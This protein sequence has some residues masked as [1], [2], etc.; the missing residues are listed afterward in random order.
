MKDVLFGFVEIEG[1]EYPFCFRNDDFVLQV[2]PPDYNTCKKDTI[3]S[4]EM[5]GQSGNSE[6]IDHNRFYGITS[7][8]RRVC[9]DVIAISRLHNGF[10]DYIVEWYTIYNIE[11]ELNVID[12]LILYGGDLN[13]YY[14]AERILTTDISVNDNGSLDWMSIMAR[15][16][17]PLDC[18]KYR[19]TRNVD[20]EI[21][22]NSYATMRS[23]NFDNP[24]SATSN[25]TICFSKSLTIDSALLAI[26]HI[27]LFLKYAC[28]RRNI[29]FS[30]IKMFM[31]D[32]EG[33]KDPFG[34]IYFRHRFEED[35]HPRIRQRIIPYSFWRDRMGKMLTQIKNGK[36]E[37]SH[38][39]NSIE[40]QK[41]YPISRIIL[42]FTAFEREYRNIYGSNC[43]RS[44]EYL[45]AKK[46]VVNH[47]VSFSSQYSG[48]KKKY[49]RN[50]AKGIE[51]SD[52]SYSDRVRFALN[53]C[54][55]IMEP[56]ILRKY[57]QYSEETLHDISVRTGNMRNSLAHSKLDLQLE[58][59]SLKDVRIIE[60]LTYA[61]RLK[62][63]EKD[64]SV[65][66]KAIARLFGEIVV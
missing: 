66:R 52:D 26:R 47:L 2:I 42:V 57:G 4:F 38:L 28:Y 7:E 24:F 33:K 15:P 22:V 34:F 62:L 6:W 43:L 5:F 10:R 29:S 49:I 35:K 20:A 61:I 59:I 58:Q 25:M 32:S 8:N 63:I 23:A 55:E 46:D 3:A 44:E 11:N 64:S 21:K 41:H 19:I 36:L 27:E 1:S 14:P 53:E 16:M 56:F 37:F 50:F 51:N 31:L 60:I 18:G 54:K 40:D 13:Y 17:E 12:G 48:K 30:D 65:V 9:F 45:A 39:C